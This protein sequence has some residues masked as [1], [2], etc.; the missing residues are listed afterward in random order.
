MI[1][2]QQKVPQHDICVCTKIPV[3]LHKVKYH[4]IT[5]YKSKFIQKYQFDFEL[6]SGT[7]DTL[8]KA[9]N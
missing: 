5:I 8:T 6:D 7:K 1:K 9:C 3:I 2:L 4:H